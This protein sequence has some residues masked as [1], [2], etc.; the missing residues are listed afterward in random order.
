MINKEEMKS[1]DH[2]QIQDGHQSRL[3]KKD[4]ERVKVV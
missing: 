3:L 1:T 4:T 2:L